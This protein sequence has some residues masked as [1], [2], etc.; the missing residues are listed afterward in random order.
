MTLRSQ[1]TLGCRLLLQQ[2]ESGALRTLVT[3][4]PTVTPPVRIWLYYSQNALC[5]RA[6]AWRRPRAPRLASLS[7]CASQGRDRASLAPPPDPVEQDSDQAPSR[8]HPAPR[9]PP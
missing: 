7:P 4:G 8:T 6:R 5:D 2:C 9:Q 3:A 1:A